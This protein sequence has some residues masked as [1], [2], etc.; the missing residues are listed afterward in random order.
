MEYKI[1]TQLKTIEFQSNISVLDF[2]K[3]IESLKK[4]EIITDEWTISQGISFTYTYPTLTDDIK[5]VQP[6]CTC[7]KN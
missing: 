6:Y 2:L 4:K 7:N 3:T 5:H 1:N